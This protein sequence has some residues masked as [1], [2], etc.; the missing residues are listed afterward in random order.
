MEKTCK[1]L[2][3]VADIKSNGFGETKVVIVKAG[4]KQQLETC[5]T[6]ANVGI[7]VAAKAG[8]KLTIGGAEPVDLAEGEPLVIDFC[9]ESSLE[10]SAQIPVLFAQ[11]WHPEFAAIERTS[12]LRDR[13]KNFGLSD[14]ELKATTKIVNDHAKKNFEKN[15]KQWRTDNVLLNEIKDS[16][17]TAAQE[18]KKAAEEAAEAK[19]KEDEGNDEERKKNLEKL[20]EKRLAKKKR[21]EDLEKKRK[22][23]AKQLELERLNRDPW[24]NAPE[25]VEA[26]EKLND[27]KEQRRDANAKLEFDLST[28]LTKEISNQERKLKR[29]TKAE[30]KEHKK[31]TGDAGADGGKEKKAEAKK[32]EKAGETVE[33]I[34]KKLEEIKKKKAEAAEKEDFGEAKKLKETQKELEEKL[35]KLEL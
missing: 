15:A 7:L 17:S 19:R 25:V 16:L 18:Q 13:A 1:A 4:K 23:R 3:K 34:K 26:Q 31:K 33:S 21:A 9:Q 27:L 8:V 5:T 24:L 14:D 2:D 11:A 30:K 20:E 22:E 12:E 32:E 28:S 10:A 6:N 29:V 35:K